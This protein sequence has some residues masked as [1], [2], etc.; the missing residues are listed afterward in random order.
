M[1]PSPETWWRDA[2][3]DPGARLV[4]PAAERNAAPI[5]EALATRLPPSGRVL[6]IAS[7][8]GQHARRFAERF[9][10]LLFQPSDPSA[11]ARESIVAWVCGMA[12]VAPPLD[13]DVAAPDWPE[14]AGG[15]FEAMIAVNLVHIAPWEACRGL[16]GGAARALVPGGRLFLYG[17]F[18][19]RGRHLSGSN[20]VF[21]AHLRAENP[22]WGVRSVEETAAEAAARGLSHAET[23]PM[24][25][26]NM[27]LVFQ[28]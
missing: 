16:M 8:S 6:E 18:S 17:C 19:A 25:A 4:S 13:L 28:A 23:I 20:A 14:R 21:D 26:N 3:P 9:P 10:D 2:A 22:L 5:M 1:S 12:N 24:P 27:M 11:A 7:G 15:P